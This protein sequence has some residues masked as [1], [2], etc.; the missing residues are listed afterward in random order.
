MNYN[1]TPGGLAVGWWPKAGRGPRSLGSHI[2]ALLFHG[3]MTLC[4]VPGLSAPHFRICET[5]VDNESASYRY[6]QSLW[7]QCPH[8][9][10]EDPNACLAHQTGLFM[11]IKGPAA[12]EDVLKIIKCPTNICRSLFLSVPSVDAG[13]ARLLVEPC[14]FFSSCRSKGNSEC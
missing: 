12:C 1:A 6:Y 10:K 7:T 8:L 13:N 2:S 3:F 5:G 9:E 11:G 14:S 4:R